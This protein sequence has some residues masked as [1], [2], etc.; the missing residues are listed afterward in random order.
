DEKLSPEKYIKNIFAKIILKYILI[1][2][3]TSNPVDPY[4][5]S[6][7]ELIT[8]KYEPQIGIGEK[9][10]LGEIIKNAVKGRRDLKLIS[11]EVPPPYKDKLALEIKQRTSTGLI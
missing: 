10:D 6:S 4:I 5:L 9:E 3:I 1:K 2:K 8:V 11:I 7:S